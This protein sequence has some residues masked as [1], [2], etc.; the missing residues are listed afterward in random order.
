M[1]TVQSGDVDVYYE[2]AGSGRPIVW[3]PGTGLLGSC[4]AEQVSA[5]RDRHRCVTVD[6]R[7]SGQTM[8][9]ADGCTVADMAADVAGLMDRLDLGPAH[10]VGFSLGSAVAQELALHRPDLVRSA[11]LLSTWSSTQREHHVRRHFESRLYALEHGPL[12]VFGKFAFWMSA[13]SVVDD[14]PELQ[15]T[16]ENR[17]GG[18]T[19]ARL[20]GTAGHFRTDLRHDT[21]DRLRDIACPTLVVYGEE[22]L[23]TLPS[24]NERVASLVPGAVVRRIPRAGHLAVFERPGELTRC[25]DEFLATVDAPADERTTS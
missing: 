18:Y 22:D 10:V 19:S 9:G 3:I 25:I 13:P 11:V 8:G 1:P 5:F 21:R 4:Y 17:L 15:A 20:D 7:G 16:V 24:Y 2:A 6:L 12:D 14:E 23:I